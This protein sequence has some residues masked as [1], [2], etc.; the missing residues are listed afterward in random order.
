MK[1]KDIPS[2]QMKTH[3]E[4]DSYIEGPKFALPAGWMERT[5]IEFNA[6][7]TSFGWKPIKVKWSESTTWL[8]RTIYFTVSGQAFPVQL[9]LE[10]IEKSIIDHQ[11]YN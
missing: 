10:A 3:V 7:S 1:A 5:R 6:E 9:F 11:G 4:L 8:R 2:D